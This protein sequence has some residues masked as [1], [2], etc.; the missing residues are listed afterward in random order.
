MNRTIDRWLCATA[1]V[2]LLAPACSS[3]DEANPPYSPGSSGSAPSG[4]SGGSSGSAPS[5]GGSSGSGVT[6]PTFAA[7]VPDESAKVP[8]DRCTTDPANT[9]LPPCGQWQKVE[10]PGLVCG[11]GSPFK[12]FVNY[13]N[14]SNNL[15]INFEPGGACWDYPSCSGEGGIRGAANPNGIAD[16]HMSNYM[17]LNLLRRDTE[18]NPAKDYN[19]VFVSYCTGDIHAGNNVV[20]YTGTNA[21]GPQTL[22]F[23]HEG[24][25]NTLGVLDWIKQRFSTIPKLLVTGCSAGGAGAI[26]NYHSARTTLGSG[27]QCSYLLDDSG[28][29][30]HADGPSRQLLD[31]IRTAWNTD[32]VIDSYDGQLPVSTGELKA[33]PGRIS[34]AIAKQYPSDRLSLVAYQMDLNYSLYSYQRFF[35]GST[36]ADIHAKWWQDLEATKKVYDTLPNFSYYLPYFRSDNCSHCVS[37]PPLGNPPFEPLDTGKVLLTPWAGSE[38]AEQMVDLRQFAVDLLDDTKPLKSYVQDVQPSKAFSSDVSASCMEGG[39]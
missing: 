9:A 35:P 8:A 13:S 21:D 10:L 15:E 3:S 18:Q 4:G 19:M 34:E 29:I 38:I 14:T 6:K 5:G 33:D 39:G 27:V 25:K 28:P 20:T 22:T 11:D 36:E 16:D 31:L 2:A 26:L 24:H 7:C 17:F 23:H 30:F 12:F 1:A 32:S 37:I